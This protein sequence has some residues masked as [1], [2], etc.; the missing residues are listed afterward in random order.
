MANI[1]LVS[2]EVQVMEGTSEGHPLVWPDVVSMAMPGFPL[3][4]LSKLSKDGHMCSHRQNLLYLLGA[5]IKIMLVH[6]RMFLSMIDD[7]TCQHLSLESRLF[8]AVGLARSASISDVF[9]CHQH[10]LNNMTARNDFTDRSIN[11]CG[12]RMM[13][14]RP[15]SIG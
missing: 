10:N 12:V 8:Q 11:A 5:G 3:K 6:E 7:M 15:S 13:R 2:L 9:L 14:G 1:G 4:A